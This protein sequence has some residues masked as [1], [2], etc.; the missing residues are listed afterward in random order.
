[1]SQKWNVTI[2]L[3]FFLLIGTNKKQVHS[4]WTR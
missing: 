3:Y 1:M 4:Q 2:A